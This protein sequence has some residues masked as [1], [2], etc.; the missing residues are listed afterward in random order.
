MR[1][2]IVLLALGC[3]V[4]LIGARD[5]FAQSAYS[6]PWCAIYSKTNGATSCYYTSFQ[7]CMA[8]MTG[9][10]GTCVRNPYDNPGH[11]WE[12]RFPQP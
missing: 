3:V 9:I 6:Y 11:R 10:G 7:Q 4:P 12:P 1:L 8:T 2:T 5:S